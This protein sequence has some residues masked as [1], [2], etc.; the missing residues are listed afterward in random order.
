MKRKT[1]DTLYVIGI[2]IGAVM[3]L[4]MLIS[5]FI[6]LSAPQNAKSQY[7][8]NVKVLSLTLDIDIENMSNE[9][10]YNV[11]G[12]FF[13]AYEDNLTMTD[14]E[15]NNVREMKDDYN[16]ISQN[17]HT[18]VNGDSVLYIMEGNFKF[19]GD[20]YKIFDANK[21]QIATLECDTFMTSCTL[22]DMQGNVIAQY[23]SRIF[24]QDY[25]VSIFDECTIDDTS[26]LMMFASAK[27]DVRADSSSDN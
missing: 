3:I 25:I 24:R 1:I 4:G 7:F 22:K 17:D 11:K 9:A 14:V 5:A 19:F 16:L 12:E 27:S 23:N 13:S 18:I 2:I 26:V 15:G 10:L 21:E 8:C 6:P 20:S